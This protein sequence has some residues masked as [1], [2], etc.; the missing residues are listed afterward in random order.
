MAWRD[1]AVYPVDQQPDEVIKNLFAKHGIPEPIR[2][3]CARR[4]IRSVEFWASL[5]STAESAIS[6]L[7]TCA[8]DIPFSENAADRA[9]E[10]LS[11]QA[12]WNAAVQIDK[13]R[14]ERVSKI[15]EDPSK[16]PTIPDQERQMM[17]LKWKQDHP[18]LSL[19][20][21]WTPHD[22]FVD[23]IARDLRL[24]GRVLLYNIQEFR[25]ETDRISSTAGFRKNVSN[26][27]EASEVD[28]PAQVDSVENALDRINAFYVALA[29][30][31]ILPATVPTSLGFLKDLRK[32]SRDHPGLDHV[33]RI[34][35]LFRREIDSLITETPSLSWADAWKIVFKDH[36]YLWGNAIT[37]VAVSR[38]NRSVARPAQPSASDLQGPHSPSQSKSALRRER[39]AAKVRSMRAEL[40]RARSD[41]GG[42]SDRRSP[43]T[44]GDKGDKG[45][46]KGKKGK[47]DRR[48]DRGARFGAPPSADRGIKRI[49]NDQWEAIQ[50][51]IRDGNMQ[52][53]KICAFFN[54]SKGCDKGDQCPF[55][56]YCLECGSRSHGWATNHWPGR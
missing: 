5:G 48:A 33:I 30:L 20:P 42:R 35:H 40:D 37:E 24:K 22:R 18:D 1:D 36:K 43:N 31:Q 9:V 44:K 29:F 17:R 16:L 56:H 45:K 26:L 7:K 14:V 23:T 21:H 49:P 41:D 50:N 34:D 52:N 51:K 8:P 19:A 11:L 53:K 47:D 2:V 46:G 32:F 27:I 13:I 6:Q 28:D 25:L 10:T 4:R 38:L 54:S 39:E 3:E 15:E 12:V 55:N